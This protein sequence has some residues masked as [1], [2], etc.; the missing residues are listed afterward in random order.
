MYNENGNKKAAT[1]ARCIHWLCESDFRL[2]VSIFTLLSAITCFPILIQ[3]HLHLSESPV[4]DKGTNLWNLWWVYYALFE[5]FSS[6]LYCDLIFYPWG[7]D[8]RYHTLSLFNCVIVSPITALFGPTIAYNCLFVVWTILTGCFA[9]IWARSFQLS[10]HFS[11]IVGFIAAFGPFR[12]LHQNHLNVFSTATIFISFIAFEKS[13][14]QQTSKRWIVFSLI[15]LITLFIDWYYGVF[16]GIYVCVRTVFYLIYNCS[17][18]SLLKILRYSL[19]PVCIL[20]STLLLYFN[21][22]T[23]TSYQKQIVDSVSISFSSYWSFDLLHLLLPIWAQF[24]YPMLQQGSEFYHH[25]GLWV[26]LLYPFIVYLGF[27]REKRKQFLFLASIALIFIVFSFG[28]LLFFNGRSCHIGDIPI[29]LPAGIFELI[30]ALT[31]I[32]VYSRF[33]FIGLLTLCLIGFIGLDD[34]LKNN[35]QLKYKWVITIVIPILFLL[36][37]LWFP[38]AM[39]K[40]NPPPQVL[41]KPMY[42]VIEVP[43]TPSINSGLH[44]FHQTIHKKPIFIAEFSRLS[45]YKEMYLQAFPLLITLNDISLGKR[46]FE[47]FSETEKRKFVS[48]I[49]HFPRFEIIISTPSSNNQEKRNDTEKFSADY[50]NHETAIHEK[51][52]ELK[53]GIYT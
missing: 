46:S 16:V 30:P 2:F 39:I 51:V 44:L 26:Y 5:R 38:P 27:S 52:C 14:E 50:S 34:W 20:G 6:P 18:Q 22:L 13:L 21:P 12:W 53:T 23:T 37:T 32:R 15:W 24:N 25:P 8:I 41:S 43:Y 1:L 10:R 40:Y 36:E 7:C 28:P 11:F 31:V 9:T 42:P 35:N 47:Q 29:F 19:F 17:F 48:T 3:P 45:K 33:A 49:S 4:G